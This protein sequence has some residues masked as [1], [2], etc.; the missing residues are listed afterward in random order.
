MPYSNI[1]KNYDVV[2]VGGGHNGLIAAC[3]LAK[4]GKSVLV[5]EKHDKVGGAVVSRQL[6]PGIEAK[7]SVYAYLVGML[8]Q[9]IISDLDLD[10]KFRQRNPASFTPYE[11]DGKH[12]GLLIS[13][14][15]EAITKKS[16]EQL[17]GNSEE[18]QNYFKFHQLQK[19]LGKH[20]WHSLLEPMQTR[21]EIK[22]LFQTEEEKLA[23]QLFMEQPLGVA[24]E[25]FFQSDLVRGL[26]F[27]DGTIGTF[28]HP[29]DSSLQQNRTFL[30]HIIANGTGD[31]C[32][33]VGGM[34]KLTEELV[35]Q[36]KKNG[37][38][39]LNHAEVTKIEPEEEQATVKFQHNNQE[40]YISGKY[41]LVNLA[42][43]K[44]SQL[45]SGYNPPNDPKDEGSFVKI[46][47][48]LRKLPRL[49][50]DYDS[51]EAFTGTFHVNEGYQNIIESYKMACEGMIP[52]H[53]PGEF[54]CHSL[55]DDSILSP[56]LRA[57]G[58]QTLTLFGLEMPYSLFVKDNQTEKQK[59]LERYLNGVNQYLLDPIKDC[60][61]RDENGQLCV[62]IATP[63]DVEREV[64]IPTG[65]V[66]H[67]SLS[68]PFV[69]SEEE[70]GM[71]GVEIGFDNIFL[72]GSGAKRGGCVSGIP[73]HNAAMKILEKF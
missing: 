48:V 29:H 66:F 17:T 50:A 8:P 65:H 24:I 67:Q 22:K 55:T 64:G 35:A 34:G 71:W 45:L 7:L 28:T 15:D 30:Y 11:K 54:Y 52:E 26:V 42:P 31:W 36:C 44:L 9:K 25:E 33:P 57:E 38:E 23:W 39:I 69:E 21:E 13:N 20:L 46:N 43:K 5:L 16:F 10:F 49:K 70:R 18:Y 6:F 1:Q 60:I 56:S 68:W 19:S 27:T 61:A 58:Y 4:A 63:V 41:V 37:V 73:G 40:S 32:V 12:E 72:C 51:V 14:S 59:V 53:P 3:Y 62:D 2:I 47:M